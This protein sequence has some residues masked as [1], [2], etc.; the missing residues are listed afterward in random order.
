M[1]RNFISRKRKFF[2]SKKSDCGRMMK[3]AITQMYP[4]NT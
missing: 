1:I 2:D 4:K 3:N